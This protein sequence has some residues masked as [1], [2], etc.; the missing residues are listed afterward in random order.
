TGQVGRFYT[1]S[2]MTFPGVLAAALA[3]VLAGVAPS[4]AA[5]PTL[6]HFVHKEGRHALFVDGAPY[7]ILGAQV[8]N[9]SAWPEFLPKVWP[10]I[11][12]LKANT[13][14]APV[15]WEQF[16]QEEG[17]FD[18]TVVDTLLTQARDHDVRLVLLW[19]GTWKNGSA[20]YMPL[21][22]KRQPARFPRLT[23]KDGR[24]VDSPSPFGEATLA[25]DKRAFTALMRHLKYA[26]PRHTVIM[27]Q[28]ENEAGAYGSMRD[29]SAAAQSAFESAVP[30][31]I[32]KAMH[33]TASADATWAHVF[34]PDA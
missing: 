27:V 25:E 20:H 1:G 12:F 11:E 10:A 18:Y 8:H 4:A 6:P 13:L 31:E 26:D 28:V 23:G 9:S 19:F 30:P 21:W 5:E 24:I 15:Y 17:K 3:T 2:A 34:G 33:K 16:E 29:Y 14:E 22:A 7:L 32:L